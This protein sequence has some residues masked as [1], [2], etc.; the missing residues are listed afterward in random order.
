MSQTDAGPNAAQID[1]W[2]A[3]A[4]KTWAQF[5]EQLDRQIAPLGLE[6]MRALAPRPGEH[7]IDVGCGCGQASLEIAARVGPKGSV[8]GV[9]ISTPML[10][11]ARRRRLSVSGLRP[12]FRQIDAQTGDL[13]DAVFDAAFS[14]FGVMF[15][16]DPVAAFANIRRSLKPGGRLGFVCWRPLRENQWMLAPLEASLPFLPPMPPSDPAAPGPFAFAD[17]DRLRSI[18]T[19]AGFLSIAINPF[20][21]RIGGADVEQTLELTFTV[22]PLGAA[23]REHPECAATVADAVKKVLAGFA[24]PNGVQMPAAVWIVTAR[25]G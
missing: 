1:Y 17:A 25:N 16:A 15:F 13:G 14:R 21:A 9:D 7:V 18:L 11:V 2:N 23:L 4:G 12:D 22:G 20:D 3:G 5:Q 10:D 8:V 6:A 19:K 24:T